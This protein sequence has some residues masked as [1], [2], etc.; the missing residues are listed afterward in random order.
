MAAPEK[1]GKVLVIGLDGATWDLLKPWMEAGKLPNLA[2]M[3]KN[4][5]SGKLNSVFP[6]ISPAAWSSFSTGMTPGK[7]G[8]FGFQQR[9]RADYKSYIPMSTDVRGKWFWEIIG[10]NGKRS[11]IINVPGTYPPRELNGILVSGLVAT[12]PVTYPSELAD[13]LVQKGYVVEGKGYFDTTKHEFLEDIYSVTDSMAKIGLDL[14]ENEDWEAFV[15]VFTGSDRIQTYM[16]EDTDDMMKY[17]QRIDDIVG[18]FVN[19]AGKNTTVFVVS[20]HGAGSLKRKFFIDTWLKEQNYLK[21]LKSD[22]TLLKKAVV[23][24]ASILR[25]TKITE[26]IRRAVLFF[27]L[28]PSSI[29][30][31]PEFVIDLANSKAFSSS[32]Y[33]PGVYINR[34]LVT[35]GEYEKIRDDI[36]EKLKGVKDPDTGNL[37]IKNIFKSDALYK[38]PV[39]DTPDILIEAAADYS[40]GGGMY[41][42]LLFDKSVRDTGTHK[43]DGIFIASGKG[44]RR[45]QKIDNLSITD[46]A[47]TIL[48]LFGMRSKEMDGRVIEEILE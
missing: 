10:M 18:E 25:A 1:N 26:I 20:D 34:N 48:R 17:F 19:K 46:I 39:S 32:R 6:I 2:E 16:W 42:V 4:G 12:E 22:D 31:K 43:F 14:L 40:V 9:R 15:I 23:F 37:A 36:I 7:H 38:D 47:P 41:S 11:V 45:G 24:M 5:S 33:E 29:I 35:N 30:R 3:T 8:V 27:G 21:L 28:K 13:D 44:I